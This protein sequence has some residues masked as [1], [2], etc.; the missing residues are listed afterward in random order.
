MRSALRPSAWRRYRFESIV[1]GRRKPNLL[2]SPSPS[3]IG[4]AASTSRATK[5][6][7]FGVRAAAV[8][9][10]RDHSRMLPPIKVSQA[11]RW[12]AR[13][14]P[15]RPLPVLVAGGH[16]FGPPSLTTAREDRFQMSTCQ[17]SRPRVP[18]ANAVDEPSAASARTGADA[19]N[20]RVLSVDAPARAA[21]AAATSTA[22]TRVRLRNTY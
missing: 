13:E 10:Q 17:Q 11:A 19:V 7:C 12:P 2:E 14:G 1:Y 8:A 4:A 22:A 21:A 16:G 3:T 5:R 9:V 18:T 6:S 20:V 15:T